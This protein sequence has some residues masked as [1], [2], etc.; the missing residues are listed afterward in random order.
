MARKVLPST[1]GFSLAP[2]GELEKVVTVDN[3]EHC[4]IH[5][6]PDRERHERDDGESRRLAQHPKG[7]AQVADDGLEHRQAVHLVNLLADRRRIPEPAVRFF[8][9]PIAAVACGNQIVDVMVDMRLHL[10]GALGVEAAATEETPHVI[11]PRAA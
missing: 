3:G 10:A 6:D 9:R 11:P 7:V 1:E 4:G 8:Q 2:C 5:A